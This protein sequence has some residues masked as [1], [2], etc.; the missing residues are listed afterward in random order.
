MKTQMTALMC[1]ATAVSL[2][3]SSPL[4]AQNIQTS[5]SIE[6]PDGSPDS[7]VNKF[8]MVTEDLNILGSVMEPIM[9][10][11]NIDCPDDLSNEECT[12]WAESSIQVS[13]E[14]LQDGS[15]NSP[16]NVLAMYLDNFSEE[17]LKEIVAF[18]QT[19]TGKKLLAVQK[20]TTKEVIAA[21]DDLDAILT[22]HI[23]QD[24]AKKPSKKKKKRKSKK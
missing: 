23:Q 9:S 19:E 11:I 20:E 5:I 3:I 13:M 16:Q 22:A 7:V 6:L 1:L 24:L 15:I 2:F 18:Y 4:S 10:V 14:S 17:E 12:E 21:R 8:K